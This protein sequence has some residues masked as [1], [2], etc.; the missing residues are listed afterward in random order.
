MKGY[1]MSS[2]GESDGAPHIVHVFQ[3]T[4]NCGASSGSTEAKD[5]HSFWGGGF[6]PAGGVSQQ[7]HTPPNC[8]HPAGSASPSQQYTVEEQVTTVRIPMRRPTQ[9][10]LEILQEGGAQ[11]EVFTMKEIIHHMKDYIIKH[12]LYDPV[13]PRIVHCRNHALGRLLQVNRFT[14]NEAVP[15]FL[16]NT[17]TMPD[18]CI[19]IRRQLVKKAVDSSGAAT[20]AGASQGGNCAAGTVTSTTESEGS[21]AVDRPEDGAPASS[22]VPHRSNIELTGEPASS[23]NQRTSVNIEYGDEVDGSLPMVQVNL[24]T[25][26]RPSQRPTYQ[27][28][29]EE[30]SFSVQYDSDH[31]AVEYE[32]EAS[33]HPS[34]SEHSSHGSGKQE[35]LVVQRESDVEFWADYSDTETNSDAELGDADRWLCETCTTRNVPFY[36][37]CA[38]CWALRPDWLPDANLPSST[39]SDP[40]PAEPQGIQHGYHA[41]SSESNDEQQHV[42]SQGSLRQ[43]KVGDRVRRRRIRVVSASSPDRN[44]ESL[45]SLSEDEGPRTFVNEEAS[46]TLNSSGQEVMSSQGNAL[47]QET[48]SSQSTEP[49]DSFSQSQPGCSSQDV[50]ERGGGK[51]RGKG[52]GSRDSDRVAPSSDV[53][54]VCASRPKTGCIIH[55]SSG[56]QVCCYRCA[57]RLRR[58]NLPCPVCRR[59]IQKVI[60]NFV[61]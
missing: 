60:K 35:F 23:D 39:S 3:P 6:Q 24:G 50:R 4:I 27:Q 25:R 2:S 21:P 16:K 56:H 17:L 40:L 49:R 31:F 59:P 53:C 54:V 14:V 26:E 29:P 55:G 33:D 30:E 8:Q 15:L 20:T 18:S 51:W 34:E 13:D 9:E 44:S 12:Q 41:M 32:V 57:K 43:W 42:S 61:L 37:H 5:M 19:R 46:T 28:A 48:A 38:K 10:F 36:R 22:N 47:S 52:K 11:G 7:P 58:K 1:M 45:V